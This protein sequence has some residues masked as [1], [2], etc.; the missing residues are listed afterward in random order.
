M[1]SSG[2]ICQVRE[3]M[4]KC[5]PCIRTERPFISRGGPKSRL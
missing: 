3:P 1:M 2:S 5:V 4:E